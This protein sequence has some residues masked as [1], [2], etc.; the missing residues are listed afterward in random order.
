MGA[1]D[2][3][4]EAHEDLAGQPDWKAKPTL[5]RPAEAHEDFS[6]SSRSLLPRLDLL[7]GVARVWPAEETER[8]VDRLHV[9]F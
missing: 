5:Y 6:A 2:R 9:E 3:P 4:A 1:F 7:R 8:G